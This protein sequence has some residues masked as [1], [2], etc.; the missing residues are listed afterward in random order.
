MV[1]DISVVE[2]PNR[3]QLGL[4]RITV[5]SGVCSMWHYFLY[6]I[7]RL[8]QWVKWVGTVQLSN[9]KGTFLKNEWKYDGKETEMLTRKE[10]MRDTNPA[11]KSLHHVMSSSVF[12]SL[13]S[14]E[15]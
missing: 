9:R 13:G 10:P 15:G 4:E 7:S 12:G 14:R 6:F 2:A 11:L 3:H 8:V 1:M 5:C